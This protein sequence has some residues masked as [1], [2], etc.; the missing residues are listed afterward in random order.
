MEEQKWSKYSVLSFL[1]S[2]FSLFIPV[3]GYLISLNASF[4]FSR[5]YSLVFVT[6][7][8]SLIFGIIGLGDTRKNGLNG[9]ILSIISVMISSLILLI[10]VILIISLIMFYFGF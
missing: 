4:N 8:L 3:I 6:S 7:I 1:L 10:M 5:I 9:K 2:I